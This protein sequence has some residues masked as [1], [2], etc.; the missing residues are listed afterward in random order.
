VPLV[1]S[2]ELKGDLKE[3]FRV[4]VDKK[5]KTVTIFAKN[6]KWKEDLNDSLKLA[7]EKK[8]VFPIFSFSHVC[9]F[10]SFYFSTFFSLGSFHEFLSPQK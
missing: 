8:G 3:D 4:S 1:E 5:A 9:I 2:I 7:V 6:P 10:F